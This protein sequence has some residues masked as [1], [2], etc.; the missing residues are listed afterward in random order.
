MLRKNKKISKKTIVTL[1]CSCVMIFALMYGISSVTAV[2]DEKSMENIENA[3]T[4][5]S[6][7]CYAVEGMYPESLDYLK[8]HYAISYDEKKYVV[9]YEVIAQNLRPQIHVIAIE[10]GK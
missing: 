1:I 3:V 10:D 9:K 4:Q 5:A 6:V 2:S 7:H 8:E